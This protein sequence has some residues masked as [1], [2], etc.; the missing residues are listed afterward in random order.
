MLGLQLTQ[1]WSP[2]EGS[3]D[4]PAK[5]LLLEWILMPRQATDMKTQNFPLKFPSLVMPQDSLHCAGAFVYDTYLSYSVQPTF[6]LPR[7][8]LQLAFTYP[9]KL[10]YPVLHV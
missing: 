6:L 5:V 7:C 1:G 10:S 8:F 2:A 4:Q 3:S 9:Y